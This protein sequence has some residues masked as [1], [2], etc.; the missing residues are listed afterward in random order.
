[1]EMIV[2][3]RAEKGVIILAHGAGMAMDHTYLQTLSDSLVGIGLQVVRFEFPYMQRRRE[4]G[5]QLFPDKI[6]LLEQCYVDV[7]RQVRA[8]QGENIK[9]IYLAGK[10][11]GGRVATLIAEKLAVNAV[12][13]FGYPFHPVGKPQTLRTAHLKEVSSN[14]YIFQGERDKLGG[15]DEVS[16]YSLDKKINIDWFDDADHDLIPRKR[17]GF[18]YQQYL[19][20]IVSRIEV[21]ISI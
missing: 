16:H 8:S 13:V 10:S 4:T 6:P 2:E 5:K 21:V 7:Y 14:I 3:G 20:R 11:M 18:T 15:R 12:F 1:M 9:P 17:S 19:S